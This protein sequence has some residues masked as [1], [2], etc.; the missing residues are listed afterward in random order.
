LSKF[1]KRILIYYLIEEA[2]K[3]IMKRDSKIATKASIK[4]ANKE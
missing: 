3:N 2:I 4:A 1:S